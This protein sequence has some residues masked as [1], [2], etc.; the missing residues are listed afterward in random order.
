MNFVLYNLGALQWRTIG[1][2]VVAILILLFMITIHEAGHY[3][4][5]KIFGFKIN[6]FAI[7][8]GP[9]IFKK[10][11]KN[12]ELFSIRILPLGGFCSFE[13]EDEDINGESDP[14]A[15]N[16]KKPW[17]R[18]L[19]LLAGATMNFLAA[20]VIFI[21]AFG[22]Y[23]QPSYYAFETVNPQ[24][25]YEYTLQSGDVITKLNG[26]TIYLATDLIGALKGKKAGDVVEA[27]ILRGGVRADGN[28]NAGDAEVKT[29]KIT[30]LCD[31]TSK[32]L[33]DNQKVLESLG[34]AS[35]FGISESSN[36]DSNKLMTGDFLL[37]IATKLPEFKDASGIGSDGLTDCYYYN[38]AG[39]KILYAINEEKYMAEKR[40]YSLENLREE[41]RKYNDGDTVYFYISRAKDQTTSE[42]ILL[43]YKLD[44]FTQDVKDSDQL[45]DGY[46]GIKS[47]A[48]QMRMYGLNVH[49]GFFKSMWRGFANSFKTAGSTFAA[50]GQ[51]LTGKL[52]LDALG[53][54]V[55][56]ISVTSKY[57]SYGFEYLLQIAGFIGVSLAA[58][59]VLPIPALDGARAVFVL[60]EWIRK[61][62]INRKVEGY[63]HAVGLIALL[64][65]AVGI[66][67]VKC[68]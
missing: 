54:P 51:L 8:M 26:K 23:G 60:I 46:L 14:G 34:I 5:G 45:I 3:A 28:V 18:I 65:F 41:L 61:K 31:P 29:I 59:N 20:I 12:G 15:F 43:T 36:E 16:N 9:A 39:E 68:F 33:Q 10:Q 64:V 22:A 50:L 27:E 57:V 37:R 1:S 67:L 4:M 40:V 17:Q 42:R 19:V 38:E 63:I 7:G 44:G 58:F 53:G 55:T 11:M 35:L 21:I 2:V 25:E 52:G 48:T 32:S 66:D 6:E 30:L 49:Y 47:V 56:T 24:S 62:P 13:G